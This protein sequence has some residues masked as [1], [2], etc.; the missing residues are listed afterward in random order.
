LC[1]T[2][3]ARLDGEPVGFLARFR[4]ALSRRR[5]VPKADIPSLFDHLIG[6]LLQAQWHR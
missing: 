1:R 4:R 6:T 3:K 2:L 5:F